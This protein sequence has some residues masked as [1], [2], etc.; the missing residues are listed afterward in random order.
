[1]HNKNKYISTLSWVT[2]ERIHNTTDR[3]IADNARH[4]DCIQ[5]NRNNFPMSF[6]NEWM[7]EWMNE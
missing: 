7:N 1:M 6:E 5:K 4:R 2:W 3:G